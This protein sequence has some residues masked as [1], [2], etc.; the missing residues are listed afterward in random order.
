MSTPSCADTIDVCGKLTCP[1]GRRE[2]FSVKIPSGTFVEQNKHANRVASTQFLF[3]E[4]VDM[5]LLE[6]GHRESMS[7]ELGRHHDAIALQ[8]QRQ[9]GGHDRCHGSDDM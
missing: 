6:S 5:H 1:L 4:A 2:R 9:G 8:R 7:R 3:L